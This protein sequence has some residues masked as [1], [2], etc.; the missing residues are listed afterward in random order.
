M[1]LMWFGFIVSVALYICIGET[2]MANF[3]WLAFNDA[4]KILGVLS[5]LDF[6]YFLWVW[7]KFYRPAVESI[8]KQ[9]EDVHVVRRWVISW[10]MLVASGEG[11]ILL[12]FVFWMGGKTLTQSLPF[13]VVGSLLLLSLWPRP[14]W[15]PAKAAQ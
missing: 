5:I 13:F 10:I 3:S 11:E 15:S 14:V 4:G 6:S 12:G 1:R 8:R 7:R 2:M 9:P